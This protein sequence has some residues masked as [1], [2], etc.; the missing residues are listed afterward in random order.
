MGELGDVVPASWSR[1]DVI[2]SAVIPARSEEDDDGPTAAAAAD[3]APSGGGLEPTVPLAEPAGDVDPEA[4]AEQL[5]GEIGEI[6]TRL[7]GL[8]DELDRRRRQ[9]APGALVRAHPLPIALGVLTVAGAVAGAFALRGVRG[10]RRRSLRGRVDRLRLGLGR[11]LEPPDRVN[12]PVERGS[13]WRRLF[14]AAATA[15]ATVAARHLAMR[16]LV[17]RRST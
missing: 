6:R 12:R 8:V 17:T 1:R 3:A 11:V 5:E 16:L 2:G 4:R 15:A 9:L 10:R 7:G 14:F 13:G